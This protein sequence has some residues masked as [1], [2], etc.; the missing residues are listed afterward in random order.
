MKHLQTN[1]VKIFLETSNTRDTQ[2]NWNKFTDHI[3]TLQQ[4]I[5]SKLSSTR[6]NLPWFDADLKRLNRKK[7]RVYN[8]AKAGSKKHQLLF[9]QLRN[10]SRDKLRK[11]HWNYVNTI[12]TEDGTS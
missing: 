5:P 4:K 6:Y 1:L 7:R 10:E 2:E 3:N 11:A 12:I 8:K 9:Q